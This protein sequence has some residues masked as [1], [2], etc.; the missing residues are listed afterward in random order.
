MPGP[1]LAYI[2]DCP[3]HW[4]FGDVFSFWFSLQRFLYLSLL[5]LTW[6]IASEIRVFKL[7]NMR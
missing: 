6:N 1:R 2:D 4:A 3:G 7:G 5:G